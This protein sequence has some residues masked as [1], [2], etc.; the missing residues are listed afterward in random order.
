MLFLTPNQ[1]CQTTNSVQI[2]APFK[3]KVAILGHTLNSIYPRRL[4]RTY[5]HTRTD[6]QSAQLWWPGLG[7]LCL[8]GLGAGGTDRR[9][10]RSIA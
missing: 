2:H 6:L 7:A 4:R 3:V 8:A 1:Q 9:T 5:V 10:H